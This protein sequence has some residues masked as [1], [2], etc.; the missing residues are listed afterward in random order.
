MK[1]ETPRWSMSQWNQ[2]QQLEIKFLEQVDQF[3]DDNFPMEIR[4]LL[5]QWI[6]NQDCTC[7][8]RWE[9][10]LEKSLQSSSVSERQR[11]VEHKVAAIKNSVQMTEQDTKYLED[12]QD[13]F[14]Y[15]YKTIQ[16]MDQGDKN[17]ILMNQEVLTL[18][19][20]LNSL[21]FKRK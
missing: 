19:E 2:V 9:G 20:M 14:D 21:D 10:P 18:Q 3:Y 12:L 5:A 1:T 6:E 4:H 7:M 15:R 13:E 17:S 8:N 16:T 11:N